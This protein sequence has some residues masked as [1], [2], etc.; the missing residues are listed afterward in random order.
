MNYQPFLI[1]GFATGLDRE[2]QPWLLPNDAFTELLDGFVYR[3][4]LNKRNGYQQFAIGLRSTPC[5]SRMVHNISPGYTVTGDID[6]VNMVYAIQTVPPII[7]GTLTITGSNPPQVVTDDGAGNLVGAGAGTVN[8]VTGAISL[9]FAAAPLGGST[10]T[11]VYANFAVGNGTATYNVNLGNT[12]I[13]RGTVVITA[14]AQSATDNGLGGFTTV[15]PGG[16]G[17]IDYT[18]GVVSITFQAAVAIGTVITISYDYHPGL[19]V[20]GVMNFYPSDNVRQLIVA[21]TKYVNRYNASTDRLDD[22]SPL[23]SPYHGT[24]TD[25]WSWTNYE[26]DTSAPRLIFANGTV[27]DVIQVYDGATV[28]AYTYNMTASGGGAVATLNARQ[29]FSYKGRLILFQT[30]EDGTLYPRRIRI[31]GFGA[32]VDDFRTSAPGAGTIEIPD[33]TWFFG[34][35]FNRDDLV[36]F[37]QTAT[38]LMKFTG[39]DV[40]PFVLQRIDASRGSGAAFSAITYLNQ[41]IAVS[42]NGLIGVDGYQVDR[43]DNNIPDYTFENIDN[44]QTNFL[45]CFSSFIDQDR[46]VYLLHPSK[47]TVRPNHVPTGSSDRILVI[48]FEEDNFAIY[49]LPLSC[50]GNFQVAQG[51]LWSDLTAANG[52][53]DWAALQAKYESWADFP[54]TKGSPIPIGGGHKGEIFELNANGSQD[55]SLH[56]RNITGT[57]KTITVTTDWNNYNIG[58]YISF[59]GIQGMTGVNNAQGEILSQADYYTFTIRLDESAAAG[60]YTANTGMASR[61]IPFECVS[62]KLNPY[63]NMDKKLKCGWMYFYVEV[64]ET[65]LIDSVSGDPI[66]AFLKVDVLTNNNEGTDFSNPTFTYLVDCSSTR[67]EDGSKK[68]VKIWIN[69]VGQFLQFKFSNTQAGTNIKVH[70]TMCGF[71]PVGRLL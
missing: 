12:P 13:R 16:S 32:N 15:L 21:D 55:N 29:I 56:I 63:I 37:T 44:E 41:S 68:W 45:E 49:R 28:E 33:N 54:W 62:K 65:S 69:Q 64:T 10:I 27:G 26:S 57:G 25:F 40:E 50:M 38:W 36:F 71:Q 47:G 7:A 61:V 5:E 2:L 58:D 11:V 18:T 48:N 53:S 24:R 59:S 39:N 66:P 17:S 52:F 19:P 4:V 31:S 14:G 8:Y 51:I 30:I 34:A 6:G 23:L 35:T 46:D 67:L 1:A 3:G 43:I 60:T 42:P 70:A 22:I 9:T 20:M